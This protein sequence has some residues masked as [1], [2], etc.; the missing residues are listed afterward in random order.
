MATP[1]TCHLSTSAVVSGRLQYRYALKSGACTQTSYGLSAAEISGVPE[2]VLSLARDVSF[3]VAAGKREEKN[4][5]DSASKQDVRSMVLSLVRRLCAIKGTVLAT[6]E[7]ALRGHLK[8]LRA[9]FAGDTV[10]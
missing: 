6:D 8:A 7:S 2:S 1:K 3:K 9:E 5:R 10:R 4:R